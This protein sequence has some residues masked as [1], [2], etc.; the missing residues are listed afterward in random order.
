M[1]T[2]GSISYA[3]YL[4]L[5]RQQ[6]RKDRARFAAESASWRPPADPGHPYGGDLPPS[7]NAAYDAEHPYRQAHTR[8]AIAAAGF[9]PVELARYRARLDS[10]PYGPRF[11]VARDDGTIE[12]V[13][14]DGPSR[15]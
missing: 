15:E 8:S 2:G 9:N 14:D 12:P 11:H 3:E 4:S 6:E 10:N 7:G 13:P 1:D 5:V